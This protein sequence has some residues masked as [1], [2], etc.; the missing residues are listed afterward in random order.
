VTTTVSVIV[1]ARNAAGHLGPCLRQ[2]LAQSPAPLEVLVV[3]DASTDETARV[4]ETA[5]CWVLRLPLRGGGAAARNAGAAEATG[6]VLAFVDSDDEPRPGWI[7]ALVAAFED[8][9]DMVA[10]GIVAGS[11]RSLVEAFSQARGGGHDLGATNG[12][13]P[14]ANTANLAVRADV[15]RSLGGFDAHLMRGSDMDFSFRAGLAGHVITEA[16]GALVSR[17]HRATL[18]QLLRQALDNGTNAGRLAWKYQEFPYAFARL[19]GS[20]RRV[21]R[22]LAKAAAWSVSLGWRHGALTKAAPWLEAGVRAS[23]AAGYVWSWPSLLVGSRCPPP[24]LRP[25]T[26]SVRRTATPLAAG[27]SLLLAGDPADV[28]VLAA[29]LRSHPDLAL[30]PPVSAIQAIERWDDPAPWSLRLVRDVRASG[31][32]LPEL[33]AARRLEQCRPSTWG[34]AY[35]RLHAISAWLEGKAHHALAVPAGPGADLAR[36]LPGVPL[37][38]IGGSPESGRPAQLSLTL[39]GLRAA[40]HEWMGRLAEVAGIEMAPQVLRTLDTRLALH[41]ATRLGF[42]ARAR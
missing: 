36:R 41:R 33:V 5:G 35:L 6:E 3:D 11:P 16:P 32:R 24:V 28:R 27:P 9:A 17:H 29:S 42:L 26:V 18:G 8:G 13:L 4:A 12:F 22:D 30:A 39:A 34:E 25:A 40:P 7:A 23:A 38:V 15:F 2:V 14:W 21:W 10:G 20:P 37:V 31:W 19:R 1:A